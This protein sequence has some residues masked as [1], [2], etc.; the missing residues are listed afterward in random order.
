MPKAIN[1]PPNW[2]SLKELD[3]WDAADLPDAP[4]DWQFEI[5]ISWWQWLRRSLGFAVTMVII[6]VLTCTIVAGG[7]VLYY[8]HEHTPQATFVRA[9]GGQVNAWNAVFS[10]YTTMTKSYDA[11]TMANQLCEYRVPQGNIVPVVENDVS[12]YYYKT[13]GT[14]ALPPGLTMKDDQSFAS[15]LISYCAA[16]NEPLPPGTSDTWSMSYDN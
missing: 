7:G 6:I 8:R 15:A 1:L 4:A 2:P 9:L 3:D 13:Q 12:N 16:L 5:R 14:G 11:L 10:Q